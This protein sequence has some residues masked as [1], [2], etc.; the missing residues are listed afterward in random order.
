MYH[1]PQTANVCKSKASMSQDY[2]GVRIWDST[3]QRALGTE[4]KKGM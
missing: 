3:D 4:V 1:F 2:A